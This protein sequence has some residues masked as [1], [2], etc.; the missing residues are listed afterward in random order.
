[1]E[2]GVY[3]WSGVV[4]GRGKVV[5]SCGSEVLSYCLEVLGCGSEVLSC[6]LE[7]LGCGS[8]VLALRLAICRMP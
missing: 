1:M 6:C 8:E 5:L 2:S 4:E 7:V 3:D